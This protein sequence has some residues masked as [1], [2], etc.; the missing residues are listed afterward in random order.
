MAIKQKK[1]FN[2]QEREIIRTLY[3]SYGAMSINDVAV[4]SGVAWATARK[5]LETMM[6]KN[7]AIKTKVR[8]VKKPRYAWNKEI[9]I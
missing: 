3:H 9:K 2:P 8:G 5:Y 6:K 1:L 7:V 4:N